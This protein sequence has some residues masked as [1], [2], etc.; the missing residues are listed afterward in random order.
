MSAGFHFGARFSIWQA[1]G[2]AHALPANAPPGARQRHAC[3]RRARELL[4]VSIA[5]IAHV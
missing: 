5:R 1:D 3:E 2:R 4:H